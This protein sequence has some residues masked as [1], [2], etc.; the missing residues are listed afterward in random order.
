M[1]ILAYDST[2]QDL[3]RFCTSSSKFSILGVDPTFS[4]GDF[5]VTVVTYQNLMLSS[6]DS[7]KY[8]VFIGPM[9][10]HVKKEFSAYHFF[11]SS[12]IGLQHDLVNLQAF[13][14]DGEAALVNALSVSFPKACHVRC[15][16]HFKRN[17]E[18]KLKELNIPNSVAREAFMPSIGTG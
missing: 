5:D 18:Q 11:F 6:H 15:F 8:P 16:L 13:G 12:L 2:L 3:S 1:M 7:S 9:F 4:L 17:I 14:T 10:V